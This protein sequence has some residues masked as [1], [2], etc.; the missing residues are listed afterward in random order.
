MFDFE[1]D[2][3]FKR[4]NPCRSP[5]GVCPFDPNWGDSSISPSRFSLPRGVEA[6]VVCQVV[7]PFVG[8]WKGTVSRPSKLIMYRFRGVS[9]PPYVPWENYNKETNSYGG[10]GA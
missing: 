9:D 10:G 5:I 1:E 8:V 7:S 4:N 2:S 3:C 6:Y